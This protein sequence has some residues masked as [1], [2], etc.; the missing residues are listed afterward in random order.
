MKAEIT[1]Y[2][3]PKASYGKV[4]NKVLMKLSEGLEPGGVF[5]LGGLGFVLREGPPR[6]TDRIS[7]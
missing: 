3:V 7:C 5:Y 2:E 6:M 1:S 4:E